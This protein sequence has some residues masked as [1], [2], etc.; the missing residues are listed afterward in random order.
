MKE[1]NVITQENVSKD[2]LITTKDSFPGIDNTSTLYPVFCVRG[3][4]T[5][6]GSNCLAVKMRRPYITEK[7]KEMLHIQSSQG[8]NELLG[9][10]IYIIRRKRDKN[11]CKIDN[12]YIAMS[13]TVI[14]SSCIAYNFQF[15][16]IGIQSEEGYEDIILERIFVKV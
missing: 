11:G 5:E 1:E 13:G 7:A 3:L 15:G 14:D 9:K 12:D 8:F 10:Q 6:L 16:H 4:S 2:W